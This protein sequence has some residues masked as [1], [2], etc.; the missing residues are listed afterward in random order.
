MSSTM[1]P[2]VVSPAEGC[3]SKYQDFDQTVR[4]VLEIPAYGYPIVDESFVPNG[5]AIP[6]LNG[7]I[8]TTIVAAEAAPNANSRWVARTAELDGLR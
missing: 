3:H 6:L 7:T 1:R 4:Q 5:A 8:I 2:E